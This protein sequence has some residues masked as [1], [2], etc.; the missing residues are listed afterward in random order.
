MHR[1]FLSYSRPPQYLSLYSHSLS[2]FSP[3]ERD[4]STSYALQWTSTILSST[5]HLRTQGNRVLTRVTQTVFTSRVRGRATLIGHL[6]PYSLT[7][8]SVQFW[9][10]VTMADRSSSCW[11]A[12]KLSFHRSLRLTMAWWS[13]IVS[14][15]SHR[16]CQ[17]FL[18]WL[19][20]LTRSPW[21]RGC[22]S[23]RVTFLTSSQ[24]P[25]GMLSTRGSPLVG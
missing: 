25:S 11:G 1:E 10:Q 19:Q 15:F 4:R 17:P 21:T 9:H 22:I 14:R 3:W 8:P 18:S 13:A 5:R 16:V 7:P 12:G 6:V 23:R 2:R 20:A 24:L